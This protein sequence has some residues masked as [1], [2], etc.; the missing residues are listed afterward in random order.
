M[1]AERRGLFALF[2]K[3]QRLPPAAFQDSEEGSEEGKV[4]PGGARRGLFW[5]RRS[6]RRSLDLDMCVIEPMVAET[7]TEEDCDGI[8]DTE[9]FQRDSYSEFITES[10]KMQNHKSFFGHGKSVMS[11]VL[12]NPFISESNFAARCSQS[13]EH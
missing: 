3:R 7:P 10:R 5:K 12:L 2:R 13:P 8:E 6:G 9:A 1:T 11:E 4:R